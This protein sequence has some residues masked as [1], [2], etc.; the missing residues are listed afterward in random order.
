MSDTLL[1]YTTRGSG[2]VSLLLLSGVV[3]LGILTTARFEAPGWP[4]FL[5]AGLHRNLSLTAVAFLALHVVTAVT[6]PF[7]RLGWAAAI[8]PFA[9]SYRPA[10]VALGTISA[11]LIAAL[12][13]TSLLRRLLG[14]RA[15]RAVHW[16]G[17]VSWPVAFAH[18][19]GAGT[20]AGADWMIAIDFVSAGA[21]A[22]ALAGRLLLP[23]PDPLAGH[24]ARFRAA[25]RREA[26]R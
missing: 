19:L 17:Y 16:L 1:W 21:V 18:G 20:D 10:W 5:T 26:T 3:V 2:A 7:A 4:R 6:D 22:V 15:W 12:V 14:H 24:R 8:V 23:R 11:E 13:A 25:A 9:S